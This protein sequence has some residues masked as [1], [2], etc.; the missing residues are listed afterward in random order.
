MINCFEVIR[1]SLGIRTVAEYYGIEIMRNNTYLCP[2][3]DDHYPSACIYPTAF[4]CFICNMHYDILGFTMALFGL[5]TIDAAKKLNDDFN[6]NIKFDYQKETKE[7][8]Y[9]EEIEF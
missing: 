6:L 4:H 3:H 2:F 7:L 5:S 8:K 9:S 1:N